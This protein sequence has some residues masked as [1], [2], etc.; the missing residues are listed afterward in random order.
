MSREG[1]DLLT[2]H[3]DDVVLLFPRQAGIHGQRQGLTAPKAGIGAFAERLRV[4]LAVVAGAR[5][6]AE[7]HGNMD[8]GSVECSDRLVALTVRYADGEDVLG[9]LGL[10]NLP[11]EAQ[12]TVSEGFTI[13]FGDFLPTRP[14]TQ[15]SGRATGPSR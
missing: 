14:L 5:Y 13:T 6:A 12:R 10:G 15:A 11:D 4:F 2:D 9:T 8:P 3:L 7:V 1:I